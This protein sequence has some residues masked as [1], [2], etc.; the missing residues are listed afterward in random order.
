MQL[1]SKG[2]EIAGARFDGERTFD[3]GKKIWQFTIKNKGPAHDAAISVPAGATPEDIQAKIKAKEAEY[4]GPDESPPEA[5]AAPVPKPPDKPLNPGGALK[6][7]PQDLQDKSNAVKDKMKAEYEAL[8]KQATAP[9]PDWKVVVQAGE[10]EV[11]GYVQIIDPRQTEQSKSPTVESLKAAGHDVPD[12]SKL[13]SGSYTYE[14]AVA[15]AKPGPEAAVEAAAKPPE[16]VQPQQL[17]DLL[18]NIEDGVSKLFSDE[19]LAKSGMTRPEAVSELKRLFKNRDPELV[20]KA[21]ENSRS[22][23]AALRDIAMKVP[24]ESEAQQA[25]SRAVRS[26]P[27]PKLSPA[28]EAFNQGKKPAPATP[29][30]EEIGRWRKALTVTSGD[31]GRF[32]SPD[33]LKAATKLVDDMEKKYGTR[34]PNDLPGFEHLKRQEEA[35][36]KA[37][38]NPAPPAAPPE[39]RPGIGSRVTKTID[40]VKQTGTVYAQGGDVGRFMVRYGP[41]SREVI[42]PFDDKWVLDKGRDMPEALPE[43]PLAM[44]D[45]MQEVRKASKIKNPDL[46]SAFSKTLDRVVPGFMERARAAAERLQNAMRQEGSEPAPYRISYSLEGDQALLNNLIESVSKAA[47]EQEFLNRDFKKGSEGGANDALEQAK[48]AVEKAEVRAQSGRSPAAM[49]ITPQPPEWLRKFAEEDV[50]PVV[51]KGVDAVKAATSFIVNTFSPETNASVRD[52]DS[53]FESKGYK[54]QVMTQAAAAVD[55]ARKMMANLPRKDQIAFIDRIKTGKKQPTPELQALA[56]TMRKWDDRLHDEAMKYKP[57]LAYL[58][59]H[60]RVLWKVIPGTAD[61]VGTA[62]E[63]IMSKRPWRGSRGFTLQHTL[64][65]MS[66]GIEKGGVP[67]SYN[68][69]ENFLL[70]AQDV[71]KFVSAN[72]AWKAMKKSGAAELVERGQEIPPGFTRL[73]DTIAR[74][75]FKTKDTKPGEWYVEEGAARMINNYLSRDYIRQGEFGPVGRGLIDLKNFTTAIELGLSPFHA[76]F[77]TNETVGSSLGLALAKMSVGRYAEGAKEFVQALPGTIPVVGGLIPKA[78]PMETFKLGSRLIEYAKNP[79]DFEARYPDAYAFLKKN[80]PGFEGMVDDLFT[81]GGQVSMHDQYHI[82]AAKG[83]REA[84]ANDNYVGAVVRALPALGQKAL[85]P[86]FEIY[87]PR[88]KVG[89]FARE[90]SFELARQAGDIASGKKTRAELARETWAFVE[91]RFGELNWDNLYWNRTFK[92]A[93]QLSFRSVTWKLGNIRGFGKAVRDAGYELGYNWY[94]DTKFG[95]AM[96]ALP[97]GPGRML[98]DYRLSQGGSIKP[99]RITMPMAWLAGMALV[100]TIQSTII[101]KALTGKYPWQLGQNADD[102]MKNLTFPRIDKDDPSQR[103]SIPTYWKD[104]IHLVHNVPDYIHSSMTGEIGRAMDTWN[105]RDFYGR[106]VYNPDDPLFQ[107]AKDVMEHMIPVPFSGGSY[108]SARQSGASRLKSAAGFLGYPKAP[109]YVSHTHAEQKADE[110]IR[111]QLPQGSRTKEQYE[112]TI[113]ER[114]VVSAVKRGDT[115]FEE[116]ENKGLISAKRGFELSRNLNESHLQQQV[117]KLGAVDAMK[118]YDLSSPD[119]KAQIKDIIT[120]H[121]FNSRTLTSEEKGRMFL[122]LEGNK[123]P[124]PAPAFDP[125]QSFQLLPR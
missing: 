46:L 115:T 123:Q 122:R 80:Y 12:F 56:D 79:K 61:K 21:I 33:A 96:K 15:K 83:F 1:P 25:Q 51:K 3:S 41:K 6:D 13:P 99:P 34:N 14:E 16:E 112:K 31:A 29:E 8:K 88:L 27:A 86:I 100:T 30:Q 124:A 10:G 4:T 49:G 26:A 98:E 58:D 17:T 120:R 22:P 113:Q 18:T 74:Q 106:Q 76:I 45:F 64:E 94:S 39:E 97:E 19:R 32:V 95:A 104:L 5:G 84:V 81:G 117:G 42:E 7:L 11:P 108:F 85:Q 59:N 68:P 119:E 43:K 75:Y 48:H 20:V 73:E 69:I 92:S 57:D 72:R 50:A 24:K 90:Y 89:T 91:D 55:G 36:K 37:R 70:H 67:V 101:S 53:L 35:L 23:K 114:Q 9:K 77:E 103:V 107:K 105:N 111:A 60:Y 87:I 82:Q 93:M 28:Q 47:K 109:Y 65:D 44:G 52:V 110:L 78:A 54:E 66:E 125:N 121:I 118:V 40:G 2:Q 116:A 38:E 62:L 63:N 102:V 71:M